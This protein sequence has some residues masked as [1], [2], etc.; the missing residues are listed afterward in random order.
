M[1]HLEH[2][3]R[4]LEIAT[5]AAAGISL[6]NIEGARAILKRRSNA[7]AQLAAFRDVALVLPPAELR[8]VLSRLRSAATAGEE[9][10]Q[11]LAHSKGGVTSEW[12]RWNHVRR[13]L[14]PVGRSEVTKIDCRG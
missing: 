14:G 12:S 3:L 13:A 8:E 9:A 6:D 10:Q 7:I 1:S 5:A 4:E 2:A 11:Q